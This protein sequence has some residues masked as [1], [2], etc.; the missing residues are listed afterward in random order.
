MAKKIRVGWII[1]KDNDLVEDPKYVGDQS[2]YKDVPKIYRVSR[3]TNEYLLEDEEA[4]PETGAVHVDV[5]IPWYI[6]KKYDDI[7]CDLIL[8]DDI[9]LERLQ[10]ND[11][12]FIIGYDL[13]NCYFE[14]E[15]RIKKVGHALKNCG[16]IWPTYEF[17]EHIY[18]KSKYMSVCKKAKIP[19][20]PT[21]YCKKSNRS[22]QKLLDEMV[23]RGWKEFVIKLSFSAFSLGFLKCT[24]ARCQKNIKVL[25]KYFEENKDS[26]EFIVQEAIKGFK[27]HWE[28]RGFWWNNEMQY[29][30]GNFAAVVSKD[31]GEIITNEP[32][33]EFKEAVQE[34]GKKAVE[35]LP[36]MKNKHG[37][38]IK[39]FL[40][41]TDI[42]CSTSKIHD[43][44]YN[45]DPKVKTFF[46]NE[47][48]YGGTN[49]F[50]RHLSF[51]CIPM[52]A[53]KYAQK[54]RDIMNL[55]PSDVDV[56][57]SCTTVATKTGAKKRT[58]AKKS[59]KGKVPKKVGGKAPKKVIGG[60]KSRSKARA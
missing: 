25:E 13:I 59:V 22:A 15:D 48:E 45:W 57:M 56:E 60:K 9:T 34:I 19:M 31:G 6:Q 32:P 35:T 33:A 40:I 42:G 47:I 44:N 28:T 21:I 37:A 3:E 1:G 11:V 12:N 27:D 58:K 49:Y 17:Q 30:I 10:S 50:T 8:P 16:N 24:V 4:G 18:M 52:W 39:P 23:A 14:N 43:K 55:K 2:L 53:E 29:C 36:P 46:L 5:A 38:V 41:R 26:P 20:A 51:D 54:A 7:E